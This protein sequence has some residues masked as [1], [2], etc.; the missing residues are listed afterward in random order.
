LYL[1]VTNPTTGR[2]WLN[3][4]LGAQYA[5]TTNRDSFN[6]AQQAKASN[7]YKAYGS[8]FQWGRKAD[9][10]ELINWRNGSTGR[11]KY[12]G[13]YT[14]SD[15][16]TDVL[17]INEMDVRGRLDWR[18]TPDDT[19]WENESSVNNVCPV[20]YRLPTAG[21]NG[22]NKEWEVEANSWHTDNAHGS[23]TLVHALE[24]TLKLSLSGDRG[25]SYAVVHYGG[26]LTS[27]WSASVSGKDARILSLSPTKGKGVEPD[28]TFRRSYGFAVRCIK[29]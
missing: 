11:G 18:I 24:S 26:S 20:G 10:H 5:D 25:S 22:Q 12:G 2:T 3:N 13:T 14:N 16:P 9:G 23:T 28:D 27:Y 6:P 7:D 4:D 19:L 17:F 15:E 8:L 29:N 21:E 1:P